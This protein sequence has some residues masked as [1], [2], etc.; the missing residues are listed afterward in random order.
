MAGAP[1]EPEKLYLI[2]IDNF[3]MHNDQVLKAY[4]QA[5]PEHVPD[6]ELHLKGIIRCVDVMYVMDMLLDDLKPIYKRACISEK[7]SR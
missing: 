2:V 6:E 4:S 5:H 1:L 7:R 3:L